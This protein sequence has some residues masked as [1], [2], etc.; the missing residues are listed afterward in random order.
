VNFDYGMNQG[1]G[2]LESGR[3][4]LYF[5]A[6]HDRMFAVAACGDVGAR[7][8]EYA[9]APLNGQTVCLIIL[10]TTIPNEI[11]RRAQLVRLN[12]MPS[13]AAPS[14]ILAQPE[15]SPRQTAIVS[16]NTEKNIDARFKMRAQYGFGDAAERGQLLALLDRKDGLT[17]G[18]L[19]S[20]TASAQTK[21]D[22]DGRRVVHLASLGDGATMEDKLLAAITLSHEAYRDGYES[23]KST[24]EAETERSVKGHTEF[25]LRMAADPLYARAMGN[26]IAGNEGL[27]KD[28]AAYVSYRQSGDADAYRSFVTTEYDSSKDYWRLTKEGFLKFDGRA[29]LTIENEDGTTSEVGWKELGLSSDNAVEG[30][31]VKLLNVPVEVAQRIME[32]D[33]KLAHS[34]GKP[35]DWDWNTRIAWQKV[36]SNGLKDEVTY[37]DINMGKGFDLKNADKSL[38]SR[39]DSRMWNGLFSTDMKSAAADPSIIASMLSKDAKWSRDPSLGGDKFSQRLMGSFSGYFNNLPLEERKSLILGSGGISG[40]KAFFDRIMSPDTMRP[41]QMKGDA[42]FCSTFIYEQMALTDPRMAVSAFPGG[43]VLANDMY[44][45]IAKSPL[46]TSVTAQQAQDAASAG[47][48]VLGL[49]KNLWTCPAFVD[50]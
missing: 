14:A 9:K 7:R 29:S 44:D 22:G 38:L 20:D 18:G 10:G 16:F 39:I 36:F 13:I 47:S 11:N 4:A 12:T 50:A 48:V 24:Q 21:R 43:F 32:Q 28:Y 42:T 1:W 40:G 23:D 6:P 30:A 41:Y 17:Q 33:M 8:Q 25:M 35:K 31:L 45:Q 2:V 27:Q 26:L 15:R 46:F 49:Y 5:Q 3:A 19:D 37:G 34:G